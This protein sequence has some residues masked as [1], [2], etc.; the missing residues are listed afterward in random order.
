MSNATSGNAVFVFMR[1]PD[2]TLKQTA[3]YSTGGLGV[4]HGLENQ[5]GLTISS[6]QRFLL[7]VN[8][9]S[10]D[11]TAF[12]IADQGLKQTARVSSGGLFPVSITERTGVIYVLNRGSEA[13]DPL[14]DNISGFRLNPDGMLTPIPASTTALSIPATN[15]AQVGLSP[16]GH[17]L[18]VAEHGAGPIDTYIVGDDGLL[19][20]HLVQQSA[21]IGPFGFAFRNASQLYVSEAATASV[22]GY[23]LGPQGTLQTITA[24]L[25]TTQQATCWLSLTPD[26]KSAY[27]ANTGSS[28]ISVFS[29]GPDGSLSLSAAVGATTQGGPHDMAVSSDGL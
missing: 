1:N 11:I 10:N 2:G 23:T 24:A 7:V 16:D 15:V 5:G 25:S 17:L 21:G 4:G 13:G 29:I 19:S 12:Q 9:G 27:T 18:V 20:G 6:D 28:T 3:S 8:A 26:K 22:S 14:G